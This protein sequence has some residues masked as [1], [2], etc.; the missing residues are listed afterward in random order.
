MCEY[1]F[2][3]VPILLMEIGYIMQLSHVDFP[4]CIYLLLN[5]QGQHTGV[6]YVGVVVVDA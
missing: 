1:V 2:G 4:V 3:E 6:Y 5:S